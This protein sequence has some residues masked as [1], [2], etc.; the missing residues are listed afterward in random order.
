MENTMS[1]NICEDTCSCGY[2]FGIPDFVGKPIEFRQY[3]NDAPVAGVK[4]PCPTCDIVYFGWY[5]Y[6]EPNELNDY[7]GRYNIDLSFYES[8]NDE[9][10]GENVENPAYLCVS[11][12]HTRNYL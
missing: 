12:H 6:R 10:S 7:K 9:G 1:R 5:Y 2:Q 8:F 3:S 11:D 4:L